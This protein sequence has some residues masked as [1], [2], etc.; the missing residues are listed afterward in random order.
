MGNTSGSI[1]VRPADLQAAA[2]VLGKVVQAL[3]D[4]PANGGQAQEAA[5]EIHY[6]PAAGMAQSVA[7]KATESLNLAHDAAAGLVRGLLTAAGAY[8]KADQ[9]VGR[10]F[11]PHR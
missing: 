4:L 7:Q 5:T 3:A 6:E 9:N 1:T 10:S 8:A 11:T 2:A